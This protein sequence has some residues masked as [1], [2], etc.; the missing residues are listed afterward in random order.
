MVGKFCQPPVEIGL[1]DLKK[2]GKGGG[3][4]PVPQ[5]PIPLPLTCDSSLMSQRFSRELKNY[6]G[7]E[8]EGWNEF[9]ETAKNK[10]IK[11]NNNFFIFIIYLLLKL[12]LYCKTKNLA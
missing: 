12:L 11:I 7:T 2:L 1:T 9:A 8:V 4:A 3:H 6:A 10:L 5:L